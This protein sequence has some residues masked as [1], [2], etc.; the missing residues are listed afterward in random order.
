MPGVQGE[1]MTSFTTCARAGCTNQV[2]Y[3]ANNDTLRHRYCPHC[4]HDV[5]QRLERHKVPSADVVDALMIR[6]VK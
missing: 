5:A 3:S 1:T 6:V 2:G 4:E